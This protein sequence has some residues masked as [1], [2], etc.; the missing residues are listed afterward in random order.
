MRGVVDILTEVGNSA[1]RRAPSAIELDSITIRRLRRL[2]DQDRS[3]LADVGR[4]FLYWFIVRFLMVHVPPELLCS[5]LITRIRKRVLEATTLHSIATSI[6]T[7]DDFGTIPPHQFLFAYLAGLYYKTNTFYAVFFPLR[8]MFRDLGEDLYQRS[9]VLLNRLARGKIPTQDLEAA[10][11][12]DPDGVALALHGQYKEERLAASKT[13]TPFGSK[14]TTDFE[15]F[16]LLDVI[17]T[18]QRSPSRRPGTIAKEN[19][20]GSSS[21]R[22]LPSSPRGRTPLSQRSTNY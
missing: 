18:C 6:F 13:Q 16:R 3:C 11:R 7:T 1:L 2:P 10:S 14:F 22:T 20:L 8:T 17:R 9:L 5:T 12:Q 4:A 19:V 15:T 21:R